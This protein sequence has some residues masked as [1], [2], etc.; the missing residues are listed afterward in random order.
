MRSHLLH[1]RC[2]AIGSAYGSHSQHLRPPMARKNL[3]SVTM[4]T[5]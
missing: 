4:P 2:P 1:E 3:V 5:L